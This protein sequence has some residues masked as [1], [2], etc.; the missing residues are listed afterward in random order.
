MDENKAINAS[1]DH[2][3]FAITPRLVW[4]LSR[5]PY[6]ET[7]WR[8]VKDIAGDSGECYVGTEDLATLC[9]M[10]VGQVYDSRQHLLSV[11]L[12]AGEVRRDPGYQQPVWHLRIPDLWA[13]N[14]E[15]CLAH[16]SL[17]DRIAWKR[18]QQA[19]IRAERESKKSLHQVKAHQKTD[20]LS[21]DE[22]APLSGEKAPPPGEL[23]NINKKN[24]K[25]DLPQQTKQTR[26]TDAKPQGDIVDGILAFSALSA[27]PQIALQGRI[28]EYPPDCQDT[29]R[30]L[31]ELFAWPLAA[32]PQKPA[33]GGKPGNYGQWV[34]EIREINA[35][36]S[37][38]GRAALE[39]AHAA[40]AN[41]SISHPA[42]INWCLPAEVGKLSKKAVAQSAQPAPS[43][44]EQV[45]EKGWHVFQRRAA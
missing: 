45:T 29:L 36:I 35:L 40:C 11:G 4:A 28:Q 26:R 14:T 9:M 10:S 30:I 15:W 23:K 6:D 42:G 8:V 12:L 27:N 17:K 41:L 18:E 39:A 16:L 1:R 31:I 32:I 22:K 3:Y 44:F 5:N 24:Q 38:H 2:I 13:K 33:R 20:E 7:L 43:Q 34:V 19:A 21:P 25:E 37:G